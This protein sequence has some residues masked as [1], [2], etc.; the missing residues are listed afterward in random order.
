MKRLAPASLTL[1][2][3]FAAACPRPEQPAAASGDAK[4]PRPE[5]P[6]VES[7][8]APPADGILRIGLRTN[9]PDLDP[10]LVSDTTSDGVCSKIYDTLLAYDHELHLVPRL[11]TAMPEVSAD[12]KTYTFHLKPGVKFQNG[13]ELT[14]ADAKYALERLALTRSKRFN[15]IDMIVGAKE[16]NAKHAEDDP[17]AIPGIEVLDDHDFRI[18]LVEPHATF[19]YH[20]AMVC[21]APVPKDVAAEKKRAFSREPVGAGPFKLTEW[22]END[23]LRLEAF[24]DYHLGAPKLKGMNLR[25]IPEALAREQ[26]YMAGNLELIDVFSGI[27]DKWKKGDR[28]ADVVEWPQLTIEYF[29]FG[30]EKAGSP[31]AGRTD[32]K[33]RKLREAI[34]WAI[35]R[36]HICNNVLEGRYT[37]ANGIFPEGMPGHSATRPTYTQDLEKVK[38]LLAEAGY[39]EGKG[40]PEVEMYVNTQ[41]DKPRIAQALQADLA[42]AGIPVRIK[43]LD[44]A[45]YIDA[46]DKGEPP[47][48]RLGWVADYPDPEN[49]L[50][51][52]FHSKNKGPQGN[53]SFYGNPEVDELI[54]KSYAETDGAK[55]MAML[56]EAEEKI[57]ADSPWIVLFF[58]KDVVLC[59]TYVKGFT[60]T[61]MDDDVNTGHVDWHLMEIAP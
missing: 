48:F 2:L 11:V 24:A 30:L 57:L 55:R 32:E 46:C 49:F 39:P 58:Q 14:S 44:W 17:V 3:L 13:R 41:D 19:L 34:N 37:P 25:I 27:Y 4:P 51:P 8:D 45:A 9:P 23:H 31:Y 54:D 40:L 47:I 5:L 42:A 22:V 33:A 43:Q 56:S 61:A 52:L 59:K 10:I 28:A 6:H 60:P 16:A 1:L 35:D 38:Q 12:G 53:A 7:K 26:E 21:T 15:L 50:A 36:E 29:G 20:L 18:T